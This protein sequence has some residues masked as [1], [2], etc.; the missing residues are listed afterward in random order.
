MVRLHQPQEH[1]LAHRPDL[2]V[3]V[4]IAGILVVRAQARDGARPVLEVLTE[5]DSR[6]PHSNAQ[7]PQGARAGD[8]AFRERDES[9]PQRIPHATAG[10]PQGG[11]ALNSDTAYRILWPLQYQALNSAS[12]G[13]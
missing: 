7:V 9:I 12:R 6:G 5:G 1:P 11:V 13:S 3:Q 4:K 10:V 8:V 2:A